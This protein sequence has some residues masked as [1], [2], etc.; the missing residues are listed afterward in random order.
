MTAS[1]GPAKVIL[2]FSTERAKSAAALAD[3]PTLDEVAR[4]CDFAKTLP[5]PDGVYHCDEILDVAAETAEPRQAQEYR[6]MAEKI[7]YHL[8][9][10]EL[11]PEEVRIVRAMRDEWDDPWETAARNG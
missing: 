1:T 3:L 10:P 2:E 11:W 7:R 5:Q 4:I 9:H 8:S 6:I